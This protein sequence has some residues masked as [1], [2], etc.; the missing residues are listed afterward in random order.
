MS[1]LTFRAILRW[2][3]VRSLANPQ[4]GGP[5][6]AG[7]PRLPIEYIRRYPPYLEALSCIRNLRTRHAVVIRLKSMI[8]QSKDKW[9]QENI[10]LLLIFIREI[11]KVASKR[12]FVSF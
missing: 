2:G 8:T 10:A 7:C 12:P 11:H 3:V 4:A 6:L 1:C 5:P 9:L